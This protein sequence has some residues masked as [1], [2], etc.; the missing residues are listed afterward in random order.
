[1]YEILQG[2]ACGV[3]VGFLY[4]LICWLFAAT[5]NPDE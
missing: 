4:W 3:G 2:L 5:G 1:M